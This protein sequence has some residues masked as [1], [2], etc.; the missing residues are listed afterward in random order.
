MQITT[1]D[2]ATIEKLQLN[3]E[4]NDEAQLN[5]EMSTAWKVGGGDLDFSQTPVFLQF[6]RTAE[7]I[8]NIRTQ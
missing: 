7:T 4:H 8:I 6:M 2:L 3:I 5:Q 1:S